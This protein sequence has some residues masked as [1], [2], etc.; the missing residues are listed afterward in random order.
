MVYHIQF[1]LNLL[2]FVLTKCKCPENK[3]SSIAFSKYMSPLNIIFYIIIV[4]LLDR[5]KSPTSRPGFISPFC[6]IFCGT[7]CKINKMPFCMAF[8]L[9][10]HILGYIIASFSWRY[11]VLFVPFLHND[12]SNKSVVSTI[13]IW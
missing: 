1:Q 3:S 8:T 5:H 9:Y 7:S 6:K 11:H 2:L 12:N 13:H 4:D 10:M